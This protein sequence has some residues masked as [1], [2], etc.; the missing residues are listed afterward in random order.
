[1]PGRLRRVQVRRLRKVEGVVDPGAVLTVVRSPG[2]LAAAGRRRARQRPDLLFHRPTGGA[3]MRNLRTNE[4]VLAGGDVVGEMVQRRLAVV[5]C[6]LLLGAGC[7]GCDAARAPSSGA[8][9]STRNPPAEFSFEEAA[10][11]LA[12]REIFVTPISADQQ[13]SLLDL[14]AFEA[15]LDDWMSHHPHWKVLSVHLGELDLQNAHFDISNRPSYFVEITGPETGNCF[16]LFDAADG[17]EFLGACFYPIH[18]GSL[19]S[20][21]KGS[22]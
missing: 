4:G 12:Q 20:P 15:V 5:V 11:L 17:E 14:N 18:T 16:Y 2:S 10:D 1:V 7:G 21:V 3:P 22:V 9:S 8:A 6:F 13:A 19:T